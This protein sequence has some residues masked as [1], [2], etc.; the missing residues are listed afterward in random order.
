MA[1]NWQETYEK[2]KKRKK[3]LPKKTTSSTKKKDD[4]DDKWFKSGAFDDGYQIGD[5]TKTIL[6]TAGD[7][8]VGAVK[9]IGNLAEGVLDLGTYAASGV[10]NLF[11]NEEAS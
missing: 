6:G 7:E 11:G 8:A 2:L 9:G 5:I 4:E 1:S 3:A 10:T